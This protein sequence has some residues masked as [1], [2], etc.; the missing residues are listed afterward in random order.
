MS[1][2]FRSGRALVIVGLLGIAFFW[3]TD[4]R[5][6][7]ARWWIDPH[8]LVDAAWQAWPGTFIG[9]AG[10]ALVLLIGLWLMTR[11]TV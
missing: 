11:R 3:L 6:G 7:L 8:T 2:N 1:R 5:F 4:V 10:S 9:A